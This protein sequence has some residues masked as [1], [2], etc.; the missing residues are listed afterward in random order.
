MLLFAKWIIIAS[1]VWLIAVGVLMLINPLKS[2]HYL[3]Q[4]GSTLVINYLELSLRLLWGLALV[5]YA[6]H[7]INPTGFDILGSFVV[8]SSI[9]LMLIPRRWHSRYAVMCA[10][11]LK[12]VTVRL[13]APFSLLFGSY[14]LYAV[15][16]ADHIG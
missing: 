13:I 3:R 2:L 7:S 11:K 14:L 9:A 8:V 10:E 15:L 16:W 6:E 12:P 4:A 5:T 1:A